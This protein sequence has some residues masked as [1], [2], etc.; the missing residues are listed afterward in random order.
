MALQLWPSSVCS[1]NLQAG[2]WWASLLSMSSVLDLQTCPLL[3][4][5][6]PPVV[7]ANMLWFPASWGEQAEAMWVCSAAAREQNSSKSKV[8][9]L[10]KKW[11][12]TSCCTWCFWNVGDGNSC[13]VQLLHPGGQMQVRFSRCI[14]SIWDWALQPRERRE[15]RWIIPPAQVGH[16]RG[17]LRRWHC[18]SQVMAVLPLH[19]RPLRENLAV[20]YSSGQHYKYRS[21]GAV[22]TAGP[23]LTEMSRNGFC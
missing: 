16:C 3:L 7:P 23:Y 20:Q 10:K 12:A 6:F 18:P 13:C 22:V 8:G 2:Q 17:E 5:F 15:G 11:F 14:V 19:H 1:Q 9:W 4:S 21:L